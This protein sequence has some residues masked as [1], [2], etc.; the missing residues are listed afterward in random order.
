MQI[1]TNQD[2]YTKTFAVSPEERFKKLAAAVL[3]FAEFPLGA[4]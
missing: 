4:L 1:R 3:H 2:I